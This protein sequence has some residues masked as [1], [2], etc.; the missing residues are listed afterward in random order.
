MTKRRRQIIFIFIS[1]LLGATALSILATLQK[2]GTGVPLELKG[3]IVPF[4]FGGTTGGLIGFYID[5]I[6]NDNLL[7]QERVQIRT[8][9]YKQAKEE[10]ENANRAKSEFLS[11]MSHE[12]RT[13]LNAI[14][15]FS[16]LIEMDTKDDK[17]KAQS[18]EIIAGG[19]HLLQ[20]INQVLDLSKI[21]SGNIDVSIKSHCFNEIFKDI[22]SLIKPIADKYSIQI[23][24]KVSPSSDINININVDETRY[25]QV[26]LNIL[27]NA[28]KYNSENGKVTIDCSSNDEKM[29]SLS[30]TDSGKGLTPEQQIKIFLPFDRAGAE[31][32]NIEGTGLGLAIS[33]KIIEQMCG[34]ITVESEIGKGS[35]FLIQVPLS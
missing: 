22:M 20:L 6:K 5:K 2:I 4:L 26:L 1:F 16:Q 17:T 10:A 23:Y 19:N 21:E 29:L 24:N 18:Q 14:L 15:G 35:C 25:K 30:V 32:S 34:K 7:L 3:Y 9:E 12:L 27:S 28:I 11:S 31:N 33:K 8:K 13:P